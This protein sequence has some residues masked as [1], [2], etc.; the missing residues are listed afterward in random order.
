MPNTKSAEKRTRS[1]ARRAA[2]N[3]TVKSRLKTLEKRFMTAL[4]AASGNAEADG[5]F[6][7]VASALGKASKKGVIPA[8][9]ASRKRSRLQLRL[10][11][12]AQASAGAP[13]A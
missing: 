8:A 5:A 10:N 4:Q 9:L 7:E 6:K 11:A 1:T 3:R 2:R 12:R 13:A